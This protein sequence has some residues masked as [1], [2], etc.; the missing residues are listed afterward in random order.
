[1]WLQQTE[2]II[3]NNTEKLCMAIEVKVDLK[4]HNLLP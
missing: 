4:I 3:S 2:D 1:M